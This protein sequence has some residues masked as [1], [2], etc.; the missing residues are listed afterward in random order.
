M[1]MGYV[2]TTG[3]SEAAGF[4]GLVDAIGGIAHAAPPHRDAITTKHSMKN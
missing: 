4:G 3:T 2:E 1:S